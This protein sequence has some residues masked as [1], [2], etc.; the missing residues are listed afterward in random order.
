M[1]FLRDC[2]SRLSVLTEA[3]RPSKPTERESTSHIHDSA[4]DR[5]CIHE[6][7]NQRADAAR[8][9]DLHLFAIL[10]DAFWRTRPADAG[11][12]AE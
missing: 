1:L 2:A 5:L 8:E 11:W 7:V 12:R 4:K 9:P 6:L 3:S 10:D